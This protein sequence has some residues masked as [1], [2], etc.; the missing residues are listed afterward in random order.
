MQQLVFTIERLD[1]SGEDTGFGKEGVL[2]LDSI[3]FCK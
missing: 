3:K 1:V 2:F